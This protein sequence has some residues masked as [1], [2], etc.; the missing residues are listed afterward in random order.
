MVPV[1]E[2]WDS[3]SV[4]E[5]SVQKDARRA[6]RSSCCMSERLGLVAG[7]TTQRRVFC[8]CGRIL[9]GGLILIYH[10]NP[11]GKQEEW[12]LPPLGIAS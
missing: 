10:H 12:P 6:V 3:P 7:K 1:G 11:T 5:L 2:G 8:Q 9:A 4:P